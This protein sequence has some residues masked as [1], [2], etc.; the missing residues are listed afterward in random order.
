MT[1]YEE[2]QILK[3]KR[4]EIQANLIAIDELI[5]EKIISAIAKVQGNDTR[6]SNK[7][8]EDN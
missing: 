4:T 7:T 3:K 2:L 5:Q 1:D 8:F 6:K